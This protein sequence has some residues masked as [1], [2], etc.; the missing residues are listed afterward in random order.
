MFASLYGGKHIPVEKQIPVGEKYTQ[1]L[2]ESNFSCS[3][4]NLWRE[5]RKLSRFL[6]HRFLQAV[7]YCTQYK[8]YVRRIVQCCKYTYKICKLRRA[9]FFVFYN[10]LPQNF[11]ILLILR[12]SFW[13]RGTI[14]FI[15]PGS[16]LVH[17]RS[18]TLS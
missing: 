15:F 5:E 14:L 12:C 7:F 9:I 10:I 2:T 11:A 8:N 18:S 1:P 6:K 17:H 16:N 4:I 3:E 13:L